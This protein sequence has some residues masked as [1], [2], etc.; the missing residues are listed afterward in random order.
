MFRNVENSLYFPVCGWSARGFG[1]CARFPTTR[2]PKTKTRRTHKSDIFVSNFSGEQF[3]ATEQLVFWNRKHKLGEEKHT[4][5]PH[6]SEQT[7]HFG[8]KGK[9][10]VRAPM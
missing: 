7:E 3:R 9:K 5:I 4:R 1:V 6:E 2:E 8:K 10:T